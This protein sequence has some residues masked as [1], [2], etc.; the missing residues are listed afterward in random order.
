MLSFLKFRGRFFYG[1]VVVA[2]FLIIGT[3]I[4]GLRFSFGVFFKSIEGDFGLT[5][6]ATSAIFSTYMLLG[7]AFALLGGWVLD[8]YGPKI[9][10]FLMGLFAGLALLLTSQANAS[11]QLFFS[12]SLLLAVGTSAMHVMAM[13]TVS[14][15]FNKKRG[16][17]LGIAGQGKGLGT[18]VIAPFATYLIAAFKWRMAYIVIGL[19]T[20]LIVVPLSWLLKKEPSGIG[21]LPDGV[22]SDSLDTHGQPPSFEDNRL[23]PTGLSLSQAFRTRSFWSIMLIALF[24]AFCHF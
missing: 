21:V 20:W 10:V 9:V 1:W 5:R 24:F 16:L 4:W 13:S 12:Y 18:V 8:R 11:W 14:R 15:W 7:S 6:T 23:Q 22:K 3:N 17:A 2:A 19:I